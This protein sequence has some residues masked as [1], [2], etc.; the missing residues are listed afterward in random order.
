MSTF[1]TKEAQILMRLNKKDKRPSEQLLKSSPQEKA[2]A[3]TKMEMAQQKAK[4]QEKETP[5]QKPAKAAPNK[6]I[7][8]KQQQTLPQVNRVMDDQPANE[9][10]EEKPAGLQ[11]LFQQALVNFV[12]MAIG[13]LFEGSEGAVAAHEGAQQMIDAQQTRRLRDEKQDLAELQA[14]QVDKF[15]MGQLENQRDRNELLRER[16][17]I[18][19]IQSARQSQAGA[20]ADQGEEIANVQNLQS[21]TMEQLRNIQDIKRQF[22]EYSAGNLAGTGPLATLGGARS[23]VDENLQNLDRRF[24]QLQMDKIVELFSGMSKAIDSDAER[25]QFMKSMPSITND[26]EVNRAALQ[27][28][29]DALK[30]AVTKLKLKEYKARLGVQD[31]KQLAQAIAAEKARRAGG[32]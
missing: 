2:A 29:E 1:A 13:G 26:D 24:A 19:A 11:N 9:K 17:Q 10:P 22:E 14:D 4:K 27:E 8:F 25:K 30:S 21:E 18:A 7:A 20:Q 31:N 3:K 28:M 12:P 15:R 16:Q 6:N 32:Q 23:V 5:V